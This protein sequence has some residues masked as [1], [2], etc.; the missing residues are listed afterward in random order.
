MG[1][2]F[3]EKVTNRSSPVALLVYTLQIVQLSAKQLGSK[4]KY[5]ESRNVVRVI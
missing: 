2:Y 1:L 4:D 3:D 5:S